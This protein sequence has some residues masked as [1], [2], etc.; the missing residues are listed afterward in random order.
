MEDELIHADRQT[1]KMKLPGTFQEYVN[2]PKKVI[3]WYQE[4]TIQITSQRTEACVTET[5]GKQI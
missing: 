3:R 1:D 2:V 5:K 4:T